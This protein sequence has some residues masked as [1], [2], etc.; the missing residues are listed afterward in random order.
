MG[1]YSMKN[2]RCILYVDKFV[3]IDNKCRHIILK[4]E[5]L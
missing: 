2:I 3:Y 4:M 1:I 5:M